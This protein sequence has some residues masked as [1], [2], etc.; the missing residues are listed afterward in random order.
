[1]NVL[2]WSFAG[3]GGADGYGVVELP[4][5][6]VLVASDSRADARQRALTQQE[7]ARASRAFLPANPHGFMSQ[8]DVVSWT[9]SNLAPLTARLEA[10]SGRLQVSFSIEVRPRVSLP[11]RTGSWLSQRAERR[12]ADREAYRRAERLAEEIA[13]DLPQTGVRQRRRGSGVAVD[14]LLPADTVEDGKCRIAQSLIRSGH[15]GVVIGPLPAYGFA[16]ISET[17]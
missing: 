11:A 8:E 7:I 10:L 4:G 9:A 3:E 2:G 15:G 16:E 17:A 6:A 12:A 1:M 13:N 14:L 5:V